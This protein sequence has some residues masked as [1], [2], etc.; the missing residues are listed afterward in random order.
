[1]VYHFDLTLNGKL[2]KDLQ[3][4][5]LNVQIPLNQIKDR[6]V[7]CTFNIKR[8]KSADLIC[9]LNFKEY[10]KNYNIFSL[11][12]AEIIDSCNNSIYLS[13]INE[14]KL[15]HKENKK[16]NVVII[17][18]IVV[19]IIVCIG[20]IVTGIILYLRYKR[21]LKQNKHTEKNNQGSENVVDI[22]KSG[23]TSIGS[24]E[25]NLN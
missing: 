10:K 23:N 15:I 13:R 21:K 17:I 3:E 1:M 4:Q 14:A 19:S 7:G 24:K 22:N 12:L 11:Q 18:V 25:K 9:D 20:G 8:N 16:Y 6:K 5:S 2:N